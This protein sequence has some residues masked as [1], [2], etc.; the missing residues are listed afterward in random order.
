MPSPATNSHVHTGCTQAWCASPPHPGGLVWDSPR[1]CGLKDGRKADATTVLLWFCLHLLR[2]HRRKNRPWVDGVRGTRR[3]LWSRAEPS[4]QPAAAPAPGSRTRGLRRLPPRGHGLTCS[5]RVAGPRLGGRL[6]PTFS[7][8]FCTRCVK[9]G[10]CLFTARHPGPGAENR[11][12]S[13]LV[14]LKVQGRAW[15]G[16]VGA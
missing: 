16:G 12:G 1:P 14:F 10:V 3:V 11:A 4:L 2:T 9:E 15:A 7:T 5:F 6:T 13:T 8:V